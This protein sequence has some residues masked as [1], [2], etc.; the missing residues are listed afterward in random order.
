[1]LF[2][3]I[4]K[5]LENPYRE[6]LVVKITFIVSLVINITS[7]IILYFKLYPFSYLTEYGQ[8]YL[9]YNVYFGIDSIGQ[10][11]V[12]FVIPLLGLFIIFFNNILA[13]LFYLKDQ[14]LSYVLVVAHTILQLVL[15]AACIF[16]I[17]LNI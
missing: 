14:L 1:M 16:V 3:S 7:W 17:L 6:D 10:W 12:P 11:Y 4:S 9:H 15:L 2:Y 13:Y 5:F 8:I